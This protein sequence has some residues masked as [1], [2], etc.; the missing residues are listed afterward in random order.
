M[1]VMREHYVPSKKFFTESSAM[2]EERR[3]P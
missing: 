1:A 3:V 2:A